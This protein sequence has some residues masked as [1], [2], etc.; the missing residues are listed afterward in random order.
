M[1]RIKMPLNFRLQNF[2]FLD[3]NEI[4]WLSGSHTI[5]QKIK[6]YFNKTKQPL[7]NMSNGFTLPIHGQ[8]VYHDGV[9]IVYYPAGETF[10]FKGKSIGFGYS[11]SFNDSELRKLSVKYLQ[12]VVFDDN[13]LDPLYS[14]YGKPD[15]QDI[16]VYDIKNKVRKHLQYKNFAKWYWKYWEAEGAALDIYGNLYIGISV[17]TRFGILL[18]Y[19]HNLVLKC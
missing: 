4:F 6:R 12:G 14:V 15:Q 11:Y 1:K 16:M 9:F 7:C 8:R 18:N 3:D 5:W 2:F 13:T 17:K 19:V 10:N